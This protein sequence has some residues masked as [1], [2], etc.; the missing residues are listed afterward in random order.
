MQ[1]PLLVT[2]IELARQRR[3][4]AVG[5]NLVMLDPLGGRDQ[6]CIA[7]IVCRQHGEHF[8]RFGHQCLHGLVDMSGRIGAML[9]QDGFQSRGLRLGFG[10]VMDQSALQR[11]I[12]GRARHAQQHVGKLQFGIE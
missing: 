10:A 12:R 9:Q 5:G 7:Q 3:R 11:R 8:H 4:R 1:H 6:A 2:Q